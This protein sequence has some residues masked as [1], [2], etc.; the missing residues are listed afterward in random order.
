MLK[1]SKCAVLPYFQT[2]VIS[3]MLHWNESPIWFVW[4][5]SPFSFIPCES[6][7]CPGYVRLPQ[8]PLRLISKLVLSVSI[9]CLP[10]F[11]PKKFPTCWAKVV[12][13]IH[14]SVTSQEAPAGMGSVLSVS[15]VLERAAFSLSRALL[16][17]SFDWKYFA[18]LTTCWWIFLCQ[19]MCQELA[20]HSKLITCVHTVKEKQTA[21]H[22]WY[23]EWDFISVT[24]DCVVNESIQSAGNW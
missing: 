24:R 22:R 9:Y 7:V 15:I 12:R 16:W 6:H 19:V 3:A 5:F 1:K 20:E 4:V 17:S 18:C 2:P 14:F 23:E 21:R 8:G 11:P 13:M 10:V